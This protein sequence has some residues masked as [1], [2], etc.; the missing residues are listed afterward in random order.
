MEIED[1]DLDSAMEGKLRENL[2]WSMIF[3]IFNYIV[4]EIEEKQEDKNTKD[5]RLA[6]DFFKKWQKNFH[7]HQDP[8]KSHLVKKQLGK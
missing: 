1:Q 6:K 2:Q 4:S 8:I 5:N 3:F 7:H